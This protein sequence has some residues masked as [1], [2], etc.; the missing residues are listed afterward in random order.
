MNKSK[1]SNIFDG[2]NASNPGQGGN[3]SLGALCISI[4]VWI[5]G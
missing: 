4:S 2:Y 1:L 5:R 3:C